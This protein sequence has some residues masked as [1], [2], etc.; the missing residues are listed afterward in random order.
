MNPPSPALAQLPSSS[1]RGDDPALSEALRTG[2]FLAHWAALLPKAPA[3]IATHGSLTFAALNGRTN[4]LARGLRARGLGAG[5][6]VAVLSGNRPEFVEVVLATRRTGLRLTPV[7]T[8]LTG[9]EAGYI[10]G[11]CDAEVLLAEARLAEVAVRAASLAPG[12]RLRVAIGGAIEGFV[13]YEELLQGQSAANI[14]DPVLGTTMLYTSGTTGRPKGVL[15][16]AAP[17]QL[18]LI[19]SADTYRA[20]ARHLHLC[21]GPLYHAAPLAFS[22]GVPLMLGA[23]VVLMDSWD[24]E[25]ALRLIETHR[26]SHTHMVPTMFHRLLALPTETRRRY[27]LSSL[28]LVLHG[29]AP[30]P[31]PVKR[32]LIEWLGPIV[33]EYYAATEGSGSFV[34]SAAWLK[35]PG[36]VGKPSPDGQVRVLYQDGRDAP[37]GALG[38]VYLKAPDARF[39]YHRDPEKTRTA[40]RGDYFTL[41]DVGYLDADGYLFLTDRSANL[42]ISGGVNI[43]PA[44]AEAVLLTHPDVL[45]AAVIGVPSPEWGEQVHAVVQLKAD[46]AASPA[47]ARALVEHCRERLSHFKCPRSVDF[48]GSLPRQEN[49]KLY[50][51]ALREAYRRRAAGG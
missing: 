49:G 42:I 26:I 6:A 47:L 31:V 23:G 22:L 13:P 51:L 10:V 15:R 48:A 44:E 40:F 50:K 3:L 18:A 25:E 32:A 9:D 2:M 24:A 8:H 4:Q 27:D 45:D 14:D 39:Q 20:G 34:D 17:P 33:Q 5:A 19:A 29:A 12:V 1:P 46:R 16:P 21:T 30:C 36:T 35:K 38:T 43:Y 37:P 7:N 11:D 28:E 41:G